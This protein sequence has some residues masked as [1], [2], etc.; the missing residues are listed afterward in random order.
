MPDYLRCDLHIHT[1]M[2]D[3]RLSLRDVVDIYGSGGF[4]VIAITDHVHD[5]SYKDHRMKKT[6][7][8]WMRLPFNEYIE[9]LWKEREYAWE[10]YEMLIIPG[11]ELT[12]NTRQYHILG[13]DIKKYV[14]PDLTPHEIIM[15]VHRQ[16][17]IAIAAHPGQ[18]PYDPPDEWNSRY[19]WNNHSDY[20][21]CFDAWEVANRDDLYNM[22]GLKGFN[23]VASSD[24]HEK[25][26]FFSWKTLIY[27]DK[28][29]ESVKAAIRENR[30]IFIYVH[31]SS[32]PREPIE[33]YKKKLYGIV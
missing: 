18:K 14:S 4:D 33:H 3:G 20:V 24:F 2:S 15:E 25:R 27:A 7:P 13:L 16:A 28:N 17:G 19:L 31:R 12:N 30:D 11:V 10:R 21:G 8:P 26:H 29:A 22:V 9:I 1:D 23:Y 5:Q 6:K 32:W